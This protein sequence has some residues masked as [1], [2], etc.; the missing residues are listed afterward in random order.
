MSGESPFKTGLLVVMQDKG[1]GGGVLFFC[2]NERIYCCPTVGCHPL[3]LTVRP[4]TCP[5]CLCY[6]A[7][8]GWGGGHDLT[9]AQQRP[10][11]DRVGP[12]LSDMGEGGLAPL[13][14]WLTH[15]PNHPPTHPLTEIFSSGKKKEIY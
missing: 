15:P 11:G 12:L 3:A 6:N 10:N 1:G 13:E 14:F 8:G 2:I 5:F 4:K 7:W 9:Q